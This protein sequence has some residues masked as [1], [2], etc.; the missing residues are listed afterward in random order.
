MTKY[1]KREEKD[2]ELIEKLTTEEESS[3]LLNLAI[4]ALKQLIKDN[5]FVHIEDVHSIQ[6]EYNQ[7]AT[8]VDDFLIHI[9]VLT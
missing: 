5:G 9:A 8:T 3:G 1:S 7:N 4:I 2:T 6:M